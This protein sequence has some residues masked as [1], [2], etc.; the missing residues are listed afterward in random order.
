[1]A[2]VNQNIG[3]V[4][5]APFIAGDDLLIAVRVAGL[6]LN[7]AT[8]RWEAFAWP[9]YKLGDAKASGSPSET[10]VIT[11]STGSGITVT[12]GPG[13]KFEVALVSADTASLAG[14][15][16][17]EAEVVVGGKTYTVLRGLLN[18]TWQRVV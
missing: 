12:D 4:E 3:L 1:M 13:G 17:H 10:A 6:D 15:Y 11:K 8:I 16:H 18:V 5:T 7:F 2:A 9:T 14:M